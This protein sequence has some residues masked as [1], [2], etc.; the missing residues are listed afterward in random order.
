MGLKVTRVGTDKT[1]LAEAGAYDGEA[2]T[3]SLYYELKHKW[4]GL[5]VEP[6]PDAFEE[7]KLKNRKAF[8]INRCLSTKTR[9]EIVDFDASGLLGGIENEG[10]R[11]GMP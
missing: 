9:P 6:N 3:N 7:M 8:L 4:N 2:F 11:P 5:L 10:K 1:R